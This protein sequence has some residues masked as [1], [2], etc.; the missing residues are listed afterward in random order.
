MRMSLGALLLFA[1][2]CTGVE[3]HDRV[4]LSIYAASSLVEA[5]R[6]LETA[7]EKSRPGVELR[8]RLAGSQVL[9]LQLEQGA[10]AD[11]FASANEAHMKA[12]EEAGII[13]R[14]SIFA[15]NQLA[16]IVP[17]DNPAGL[18]TFLDLERA[19][20]LVIGT[21]QVPVGMYARVFLARAARR[22]GARVWKRVHARIVSEETNVRLIRAKVEL[23]EAD[24][25]FVY[26]TDARAS[27]RTRMIP[28]PAELNVR[29]RY[30]I[31]L[32]SDSRHPAEAESFIEFVLSEAGQE[33]LH[34]HGF[35][36]AV[37]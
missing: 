11:V 17:V 37:P 28:I 24:A 36:M 5:F 6:D 25:A 20:R 32:V 14:S 15:Y 7:F 23:G 34:A 19:Q 18:E 26:E 10:V 2:A 1:G 22:F 16:L 31:G 29:A 3:R 12:L 8:V 21:E 35:S 4:S 27:R 9:R 13:R 30:P 33:I